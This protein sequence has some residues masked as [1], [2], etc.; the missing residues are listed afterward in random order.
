ME[1]NC[2]IV[3]DTKEF[4]EKVSDYINS[5][6]IDKFLDN[7]IYA[8]NKEFRIAMIHGM[9]IALILVGLCDLMYIKDTNE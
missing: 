7:T 9:T 3:V 1:D 6:K 8:G 2:M 5:N 4:Q